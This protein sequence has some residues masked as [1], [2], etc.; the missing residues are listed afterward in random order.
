MVEDLIHDR[1]ERI[2]QIKKGKSRGIQVRKNIYI[3]Y[4]FYGIF[5]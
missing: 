2:K 5:R 1:E 3:N 4:I